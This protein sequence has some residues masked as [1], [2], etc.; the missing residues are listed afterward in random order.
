[1]LLACRPKH[2]V[3][4]LKCYP[5][6]Q[7]TAIEVKPNAS[8]LSYLLYYASTRRSK[9]PKVVAFLEKKT[10][11]DVWH[12]RTWN[13]QIT[14]C[15]L[16]AI[17]D[18]VPRDLPIFAHSVLNVLATVLRSNDLTTAEDSI[19]TFESFCQH[20]DG[21]SLAT[22]HDYARPFESVVSTYA[23]LAGKTPV[24]AKGPPNIPVLLRWR[25]VG[26]QA[27]GC[28]ASSETLSLDGGK[29]L[30][31]VI[32]VLLEQLYV[33][34]EERLQFLRRRAQADEQLESDKAIKRR[35]SNATVQTL[36]T[37]HA[38]A[39]AGL[40][41]TADADAEAEEKNGLL[42]VRSLRQIFAANGAAHI[43]GSTVAIVRLVLAR[44]RK[45]G[46]ENGDQGA[47]D[48]IGSWAAILIE[49]VA[50]WTPV[51]ARFL[52]LLT[53]V[54]A[55]T[56]RPV[57]AD[58]FPQQMVLAT[59]IR[60]LLRYVNLIGLSV[61]DVLL[62]L[63]HRVLLVIDGGGDGTGMASHRSPLGAK[64]LDVDPEKRGPG[65]PPRPI[66][67]KAGMPRVD[68]MAAQRVPL[69][70]RLRLCIGDMA[71]HVYY[72]DQVSDMLAAVV[73][74]MK[75]AA[76][77][78]LNGTAVTNG[79][80]SAGT[81][82]VSV[83]VPD[84][85]SV[86]QSF[87][88]DAAR[89][90][91]LAVVKE[92]LQVANVREPGKESTATSAS[93]NRVWFDVWDGSSWLLR[94]P[95]VRVRRAY[96]DVLLTWLRLE[97][98]PGAVRRWEEEGSMLSSKV[99]GGGGGDG[100][101]DESNTLGVG[102]ATDT[103]HHHRHSLQPPRSSFMTRLHLAIYE[104]TR[105][106]VEDSA[107][108]MQ[109]MHLLLTRLVEKLGVTAAKAGLPMVFQLQEDIQAVASP[110]AKIRLASVA[111]GYFCTLSQRFGFD[112]TVVGRDLERERVRRQQHG[113]WMSGIQ[114]PPLGIEQIESGSASAETQPRGADDRV[115][116]ESVRPFDG[117]TA[118]VE[119][120]V[121]AYSVSVSS[122]PSSP[123][124]SPARLFASPILSMAS[125]GGGS[126]GLTSGH[127][128]PAWTTARMR[129]E[130][131][132]V[133]NQDAIAA[134]FQKGNSRSASSANGSKRG[135]ALN[136]VA[137]GSGPQALA[138][139]NDSSGR[140]TTTTTTTT[141]RSGGTDGG[142]GS[143]GT[144]S[145]HH[146][147]PRPNHE[148]TA[149]TTTTTT[150]GAGTTAANP[151]PVQRLRQINILD[152]RHSAARLSS[153]PSSIGS[154]ASSAAVLGVD[155]L[156]RVLSGDTD[157]LVLAREMDR[158]SVRGRQGSRHARGFLLRRGSGSA[159]R[160]DGGTS[161]DESGS[162]E[163]DDGGGGGR[164]RRRRR[165]RN[166]DDDRAPV[167]DR[168]VAT[169]D[170][171]RL[172]TAGDGHVAA[173]AANASPEASFAHGLADA[174][175]VELEPRHAPRQAASTSASALSS[176]EPG[177]SRGVLPL[178]GAVRLASVPTP[179]VVPVHAPGPAASSTPSSSSPFPA[180]AETDVFSALPANLLVPHPAGG[181]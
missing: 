83:S 115:R 1:M 56:K 102:G 96:T 143:G 98:E 26:L 113:L 155:D 138:G 130:M 80:P 20:H 179:A 92:I 74:R 22:G 171:A 157:A 34:N 69:L 60:W 139:G 67:E 166:D 85:S 122:P 127:T 106:R 21:P 49:M 159:G 153:Q 75:P 39:A 35:I 15:I 118:L 50:Q 101:G 38:D 10:T 144:H 2:Q 46:H 53:V 126:P 28:I 64:P 162:D 90:A 51:Q 149:P 134:S 114:I 164:S 72:A 104:L 25:T 77:P 145:P 172:E 140:G 170:F 109:L 91:A 123:P 27:M 16:K 112:G 105:D 61:M 45:F 54:D 65:Q 156:K 63:L 24:P 88:S 57:T 48:R 93:R 175:R 71:T 12:G 119:L 68:V 158:H 58:D 18:K 73:R 41:S 137:A 3:L 33:G 168:S 181:P 117:R 124:G 55:L 128:T 177:P 165:R 78:S 167:Q 40:G 141:V 116:R 108:D 89:L 30:E 66:G 86:R 136:G 43:R 131:L 180:F 151:L 4:V 132:A 174:P 148:P 5:K 37:V 129:D 84:A 70:A 142:A 146:R 8:E 94:D 110:T 36:E 100:G 7:K 13:I 82:A 87:G 62:D 11:S 59:M 31:I 133:W 23:A 97:V 81:R 125:I 103:L 147:H 9:L 135:G 76:H 29:P 19:P 14:L 152:D 79:N 121:N 95:N 6:Y 120:I 160:G 107:A 47:I 176:R 173:A 150:A 178:P 44:V 154:R 32:P 111:H 169:T 161:S 99:R 42:A 163:E 52:I 17:I